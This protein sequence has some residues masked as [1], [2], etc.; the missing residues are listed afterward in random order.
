[1][2]IFIQT[3]KAT[4]NI[5][6]LHTQ[7]RKTTRYT[8]ILKLVRSGGEKEK[9]PG[10]VHVCR[11]GGGGGVAANVGMGVARVQRGKR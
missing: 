6:G 10:V 1:M 3:N 5:F 2:K 4:T 11:G 8:N 9:E 7:P